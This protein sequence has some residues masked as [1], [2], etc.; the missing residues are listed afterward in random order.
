[1]TVNTKAMVG[2]PVMTRAD[3]M[4]GKVASFDLEAA[5]GRL[6][7]LRVKTR[8]LVQG[9]LNNELTVS[10]DAVIEITPTR[11]VVADAVAKGVARSLAHSPDA[12]PSPGLMKEG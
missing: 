2:V 8:S 7:S 10:W 9:L 6:V 5:T 3:Q 11:V 4:L 12:V 1:M